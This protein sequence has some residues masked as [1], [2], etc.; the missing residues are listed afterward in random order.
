MKT[1]ILTLL[2]N[3]D[4]YL[5]GQDLC[6]QFGVSRTAV[7]KAINQLKEEGYVIE[8]VPNKGYSLKECPDVLAYSEIKSV[9]T[10]KWAG[11][12]LFCFDTIDSTNTKAKQLAEEG[13]NHGALVV[14]DNQSGGKGRRGRSWESPVSTGIFMTLI[15]KP[16]LNPSDASMLTLVMAIAV[17]KA[18]NKLTKDSCFIK[19][20]NDIVLNRK[21]ICGI[22]TEMSAEMDYINHIVIG[23]GINVNMDTFQNELKEKATSI[24]IEN[25][26][27]VKRAELINQVMLCFEE[28]YE[29]FMM[30]HTLEAQKERYNNMLVSLDKEVVIMEPSKEFIGI[31]RGINS[32]GELMV[33]KEDGQMM[34]IYAGEVSV[35]G[36]Y[37]YV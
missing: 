13:A 10:S 32:K 35:R 29:I 25:G 28:E 8:A 23:I 37:G 22:L 19:W 5:S 17:A 2:K 3:T 14:S 12:E 16:S 11:Q 1:K 9:L 20:P 7:W 31:A 34:A 4:S 15:L 24:K 36:I 33:E 30:H 18:C 27:P 26:Y 21:K 6:N